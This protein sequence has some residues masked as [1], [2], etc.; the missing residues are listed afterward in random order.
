MRS[1]PDTG[2]G[3][4]GDKSDMAGIAFACVAAAVGNDS[5]PESR[6]ISADTEIRKP[7][8]AHAGMS[9]RCGGCQVADVA[10]LEILSVTSFRS[11]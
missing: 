8:F 9:A 7:G 6:V 4:E 2:A 3:A 11:S 5:Q 1:L 10:A